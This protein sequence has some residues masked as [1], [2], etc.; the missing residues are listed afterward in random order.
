M[1]LNRLTTYRDELASVG[2]VTTDDDM[3]SLTLVGLPRRW[4]S[5]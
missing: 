4:N 2:V 1:F 5:Y 3:V